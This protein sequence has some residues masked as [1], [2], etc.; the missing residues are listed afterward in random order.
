MLKKVI[1]A[2]AP[3]VLMVSTLS[4]DEF[5][6]DLASINDAKIEIEDVNLDNLDVEQLASEAGEDSED[7]IEACF[8]RFGYGYR[9]GYGFNYYRGCYNYCYPTYYYCYRP[10]YHYYTY[11]VVP[12][13]RHYWG[14]Y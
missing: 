6:L 9:C 7:A 13:L 12:V 11:R 3:M 5:N 8:R 10:V 4:A 2:M 14:C 1:F